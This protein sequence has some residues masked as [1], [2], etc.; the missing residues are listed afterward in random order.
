VGSY[1]RS[2]ADRVTL[3]RKVSS[4]EKEVEEKVLQSLQFDKMRDQETERELDCLRRI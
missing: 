1:N 2:Q 4:I 3:Y